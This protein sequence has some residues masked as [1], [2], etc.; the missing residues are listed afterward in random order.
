MEEL[1]SAN[2]HNIFI[3]VSLRFTKEHFREFTKRKYQ[4]YIIRINPDSNRINFRISL[5]HFI[6]VR[7]PFSIGIPLILALYIL[8][9]EN[10]YSTFDL[11]Y[12]IEQF[13]FPYYE[14]CYLTVVKKVPFK[15]DVS[16]IS[17]AKKLLDIVNELKNHAVRLI[18]EDIIRI[19]SPRINQYQYN[20]IK[21]DLNF[22]TIKTCYYNIKRLQFILNTETK[23]IKELE[24]KLVE[25][26]FDNR[27]TND[28]R[29]LLWDV[30]KENSYEDVHRVKDSD[31]EIIKS[32]DEQEVKLPEIGFS[33]AKDFENEITNFY[34]RPRVLY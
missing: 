13:L 10:S 22:T 8:S 31:V 7:K 29:L 9:T 4:Q 24:Y 15:N 14:S 21:N 2:N 1:D 6:C 23:K 12:M 18:Q 25:E 27:N 28:I 34:K 32:D 19:I 20:W 3:D 26:C 11:V 16:V 5:S 33:E 30:R 17:K